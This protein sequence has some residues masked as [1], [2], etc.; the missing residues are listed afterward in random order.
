MMNMLSSAKSGLRFTFQVAGL[1]EDTFSVGE[2]SLQEGLSE[3]FTLNLTLVKTHTLNP[4][5]PRTEVDLTALLM[6]EAVLQIF[7][8]ELEQRKITGIISHADWAGTDGNKTLYTLT[9]RPALW[10]LTLNQ[11]SRIFHQ[12]NVPAILNGLL[13]KHRVR[14]DSKLYDTHQD[15]EYV[16]QKRES[17]YAFFSRLATE[18]GISFWFEDET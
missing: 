5:K 1:P 15:R 8:G 4:F 17:D 11:E 10:R 9:V 12:Q 14:A 3:L 13:K 18:E 16:T 6:Q 7:H 2:F